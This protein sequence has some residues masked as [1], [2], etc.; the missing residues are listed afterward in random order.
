M[1]IGKLGVAIVCACV[2][3]HACVTSPK[4]ATARNQVVGGSVFVGC[5]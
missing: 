5:V 3:V 2:Y 4:M 1:Q